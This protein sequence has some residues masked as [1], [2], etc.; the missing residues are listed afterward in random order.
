MS[1]FA[2]VESRLPFL[3][4][5]I[6]LN[7]VK[8]VPVSGGYKSESKTVLVRLISVKGIEF[9]QKNKKHGEKDLKVLPTIQEH[10]V[11]HP[12]NVETDDT[13][14]N[15]NEGAIMGNLEDLFEEAVNDPAEKNTCELLDTNSG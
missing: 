7:S 10:L 1:F 14:K 8:L 13:D 12:K 9:L 5:E 3:I 4:Q 6:D 15:D 2:I 11:D